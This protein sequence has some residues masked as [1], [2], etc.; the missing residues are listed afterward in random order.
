MRLLDR[1]NAKSLEV[2]Q[3]KYVI[4][5][6][7]AL[8]QLIDEVERECGVEVSQESLLDELGMTVLLSETQGEDF[9]LARD[10]E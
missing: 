6:L 10:C 7:N 2:L 1:I 4:V 5:N 3:P 9:V 8:A